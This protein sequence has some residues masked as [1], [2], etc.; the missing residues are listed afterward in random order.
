M[1]G[2]RRLAAPPLPS[3]AGLRVLA[4]LVLAVLRADAALAAAGSCGGLTMV[5]DAGVAAL[6][7][8]IGSR[9]RDE[10]LTVPPGG[11]KDAVE[12]EHVETWQ[13]VTGPRPVTARPSVSCTSATSTSSSASSTS[14]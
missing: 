2:P 8:A 5:A 13:L 9:G 7:G 6:P 10:T 4:E 3:G 12:V 1:F 11:P 14:G